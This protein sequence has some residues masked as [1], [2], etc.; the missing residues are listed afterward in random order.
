MCRKFS[1]QMSIS[2]PLKK[3]THLERNGS[4]RCFLEVGR[5]NFV[6]SLKGKC[7]KEVRPRSQSWSVHPLQQS[8]W[9]PCFQCGRSGSSRPTESEPLPGNLHQGFITSGGTS[10]SAGDL[11]LEHLGNSCSL[12]YLKFN[13]FL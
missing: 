1:R 12:D 9:G 4:L 5:H 13:F 3:V 7:S 8:L 6:Q 11:N 2:A 10:P